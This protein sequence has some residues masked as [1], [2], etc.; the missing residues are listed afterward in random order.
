MLFDLLQQHSGGLHTDFSLWN[1]Y[2]RQRRRQQ[3]DKGTVIV[4]RDRQ[5]LGTRQ[6][7]LVKRFV[8]AQREKI[9]G[10]RNSRSLRKLI[11]QAVTRATPRVA[12]EI[13]CDHDRSRRRAEAVA[14]DRLAK[15]FTS[16]ST[17]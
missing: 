7:S 9:I 10:C 12:R 3:I 6:P 8:A 15:P 4:T 1:S 14:S 13:L 2:S 5:I 17:C 16:R 11:E